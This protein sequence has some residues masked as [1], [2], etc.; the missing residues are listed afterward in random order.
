[1]QTTVTQDDCDIH[2]LDITLHFSCGSHGN[3]RNDLS[4]HIGDP[5]ILPFSGFFVNFTYIYNQITQRFGK[6]MFLDTLVDFFLEKL[7][8]KLFHGDF[9]YRYQRDG[10]IAGEDSDQGCYGYNGW[11]NLIYAYATGLQGQNFRIV[12]QP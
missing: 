8:C 10:K 7:V 2:L 3:S 12:C 4:P 1:M 11:Q 6:L 5:D 9:T